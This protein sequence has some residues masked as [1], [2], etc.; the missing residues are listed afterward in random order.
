[1]E[2]LVSAP[3]PTV[4]K[5]QLSSMD[6]VIFTLIFFYCLFVESAFNALTKS[7][8]TQKVP[9]IFFSKKLFLWESFWN[10]YLKLNFYVIFFTD[11]AYSTSS[12]ILSV[13]IVHLI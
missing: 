11:T 1:M 6:S 9:E 8:I 2:S 12:N 7:L 5:D 3:I 10:I 4:F 13:L